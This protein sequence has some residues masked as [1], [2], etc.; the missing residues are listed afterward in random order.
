MVD[1]GKLEAGHLWNLHL[2]NNLS[3]I[4]F[5]YLLYLEDCALCIMSYKRILSFPDLADVAFFA[6]VTELGFNTIK[7]EYM[8]TTVS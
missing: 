8:S 4:F 3:S 2:K 6:Q 7:E 1:Y 5:F